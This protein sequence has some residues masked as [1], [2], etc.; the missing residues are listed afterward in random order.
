MEISNKT[1]ERIF[2]TEAICAL[3]GRSFQVDYEDKI[4]CPECDR[5]VCDE[6]K[7]EAEME[8][9]R[10]L[11]ADLVHDMSKILA[12]LESDNTVAVSMAK[13]YA[14]GVIMRLANNKPINQCVC[15]R[16]STTAYWNAD[17]SHYVCNKYCADA[18]KEMLED[19]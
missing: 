15:G 17:L 8:A 7:T 16:Y 18:A 14:K 1:G 3:C 5:E 19:K 9:L 12:H 11:K 13:G 10:E 6:C 4:I 2:D